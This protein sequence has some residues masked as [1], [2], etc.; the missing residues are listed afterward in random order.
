MSDPGWWSRILGTKKPSLYYAENGLGAELASKCKPLQEGY[1]PTPWAANAHV[2]TVLAVLR[3]FTQSSNYRRQLVLTSDGGTVALDW[4][5]DSDVLSAAS[6]TTPILLVLHGINGGSHEGYCK[7]ACAVARSRGWR[8]VVLNYR[9]CNGLPLTSPRGYNALQSADVEM[10]I[11]SIKGRFPG[12][13]LYAVGYSL[14]SLL[15]TQYIARADSAT[16]SPGG[17]GLAAAVLISS[18]FCIA[19]T[20]EKFHRP[21][22]AQYLYNLAVAFKLREYVLEHQGRLSSGGA[23]AAAAAAAALG[24]WTVGQFDDA[25]LPS[26]LGYAQRQQYYADCSLIDALSGVRTPLLM[27][28]AEDDPF[29]GKLPVEEC[30]LNP[31]AVL[32]VTQRG[33]HLAFLEGLWPLGRSWMDRVLIDFCDAAAQ[34]VATSAPALTPAPHPR[35]SGPARSETGEAAGDGSRQAGARSGLVSIAATSAAR[36]GGVARD[37]RPAPGAPPRRRPRVPMSKL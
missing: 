8:A 27:L 11:A 22:S 37:A 17:S 26:A 16:A 23:A 29:L 14:G 15:L 30:R 28:A 31:Y 9:G 25:V 3:T 5:N 18:P 20:S 32:A 6:A 7:W 4:F 36:A 33:G 35:L 2:Q 1:S 21:W 13:P 10:A 19:A 24:T 12:A 34:H